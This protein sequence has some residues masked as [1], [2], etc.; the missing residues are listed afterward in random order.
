[1][2]QDTRYMSRLA[3]GYLGLLY[4]GVIDADR[5]ADACRSARVASPP[6]SA[7]SGA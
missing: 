3:T 5:H 2:L 1:M 6:I 7:M 4:G